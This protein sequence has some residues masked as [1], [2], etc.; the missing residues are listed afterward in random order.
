MTE[1]PPLNYFSPVFRRLESGTVEHTG[2]AVLIRSYESYWLVTAAHVAA[3]APRESIWL[4]AAFGGF[5]QLIGNPVSS[6][7]LQPDEAQ[8]PHHADLCGF[9][10]D[11]REAAALSAA[12]LGFIGLHPEAIDI[13]AVFS[14]SAVGVA[15]GFPGSG[16]TTTTRR[17]TWAPVYFHD[18]RFANEQRL[19]KAGINLRQNFA[20]AMQNKF[21][22]DGVHQPDFEVRGLS[23]GGIFRLDDDGP[24]LVGIVTEFHTSS[25]LLIGTR[26][27]DL[28]A[29]IADHIK[30]RSPILKPM[31]EP[32]IHA[33]AFSVAQAVKHSGWTLPVSLEP[34]AKE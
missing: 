2:S 19:R 16:V 3:R 18:F 25:G 26:L 4:P 6:S 33:N 20:L 7:P 11:D 28:F 10:L 8:K 12:G 17:V 21:L 23:G 24:R 32:L 14:P 5:F 22:R 27:G 9:A 13:T 30:D 29:S 31:T 34:A 15:A 1:I